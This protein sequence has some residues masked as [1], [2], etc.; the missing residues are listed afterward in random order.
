MSD[1]NNS[2]QDQPGLWDPPVT[3]LGDHPGPRRRAPQAINPRRAGREGAQPA[4]TAAPSTTPASR[5]IFVTED[6][7]DAD[8]VA[9]YLGVPKQTLYAWRHSGKGPKGFRVGKHLRWRAQTVVEWALE[10]ERDQ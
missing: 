6:L 4:R 5:E 9:A 10:L 2:A 8:R 1:N 7:W 3:H